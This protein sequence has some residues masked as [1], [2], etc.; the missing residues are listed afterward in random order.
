MYRLRTV[1]VRL[2]GSVM[3]W[4]SCDNSCNFSKI[5]NILTLI[6]RKNRYGT[7]KVKL[8][9]FIFRRVAGAGVGRSRGFWL[10]SEPKFSPGSGSYSYST[11]L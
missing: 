6:E 5:L 1:A 2:R 8:F 7:L 4:Q 11:V 9:V 10:D 3:W